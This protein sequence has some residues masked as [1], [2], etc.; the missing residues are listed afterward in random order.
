MG[1]KELIQVILAAQV[2]GEALE[3]P[4]IW[5]DRASLASDIAS[6]LAGAAVLLNVFGVDINLSPENIT[7]LSA[8][9]A[10]GVFVLARLANILHRAAN[11]DAGKLQ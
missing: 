10:T 8:G 1:I 9:A 7:V 5:A 3:D 2:R 6:L 4:H 11:K